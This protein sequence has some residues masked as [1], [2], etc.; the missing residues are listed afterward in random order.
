M[1]EHL[2]KNVS[3]RKKEEFI[4][5]IREFFNKTILNIKGTI[6]DRVTDNFSL[7]NT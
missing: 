5:A 3:Y 7:L 6:Q 4:E 2:S 1:H